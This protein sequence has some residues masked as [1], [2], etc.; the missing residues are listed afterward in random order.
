MKT[1]SIVKAFKA[2]GFFKRKAFECNVIYLIE[3]HEMKAIS[4]N[5]SPV[6]K[7]DIQLFLILI[8]DS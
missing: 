2:R 4:L 3:N 5:S 1:F 6:R 8:N 7:I